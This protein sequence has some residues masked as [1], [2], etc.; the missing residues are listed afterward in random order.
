[1]KRTEWYEVLLTPDAN[2]EACSHLLQHYQRGEMQEDLCFGL[3]TPSTGAHRKTA[4][5][6][7]ILRPRQEDRSLHGNASFSGGYLSRA[8]RSAIASSQ[9]LVFMHS[10]PSSGWQDMSMPDVCAERDRIAD[11]ARAT[12][13]PLV[14]MT[15]GIDGHWSARFWNDGETARTHHWCKKVRVLSKT[16]LVIWRSPYDRRAADRR[17]QRR[18]VDS[19]GETKQLDLEVLRIGIVGLGSVGSVVAEG[20]ARIGVRELVLIDDDIVEEHNLDRLLNASGRD[21]GRAKTDVAERAI[22][23]AST[24]SDITVL[25]YRRKIQHRQAYLAAKDCDILISCV[26][27]PVARDLLNRTAYR[28][29]IPVVDGGVEVRK[30]PHTG[31]MNA[32][33]WKA[34]I[35]APQTECLRCKGQ[36]TSSD[37]MLELDGSWKDPNYIRGGDADSRSAEN[38]FCL[39]LA[40]GSELLNVAIRM[41]IAEHWWPAQ[42]GIERNLVTGRT[43]MHDTKCHENCTIKDEWWTG[44]HAKE[45]GY[46]GGAESNLLPDHFLARVVR[47]FQSWGKK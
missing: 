34:H 12:A 18:T 42:L 16:R 19:W 14:G 30:D 4:M 7:R 8:V 32:G 11:I 40:T 46:L 25:N 3:W 36:Y 5:V 20:L 17:R 24:A 6:T 21:I 10:H 45:V 23:A 41:V 37:V 47:W 2:E 39:S 38:V 22:R 31:N 28:D 27:S 44:D 1:M 15:L 13:N 35:A 29:G 9:G 33:R 43:K 26:D